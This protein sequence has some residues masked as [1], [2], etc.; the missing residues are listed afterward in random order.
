MPDTVLVPID[1]SE[2]SWTALDYA[3]SDRPDDRIVVL[4][5]INPMEGVYATDA[6]G[7]DYWDG[8]YD[9]AEERADRLAEEALERAGD[10]ADAV[11]TAR[12]ASTT[13]SSV[14]TVARACP[15]SSSGASPSR[16]SAVRASPSRSSGSAVRS[17]VPRPSRGR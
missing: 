17:A 11:E 14:A 8:W 13:S 5:V 9:T 10:R 6:M 1:G 3:L 16:W 4:H 12:T 7:G 2:Q 15:G